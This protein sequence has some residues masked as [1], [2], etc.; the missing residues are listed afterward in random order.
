[1]FE[2]EPN[3]DIVFRN[4]L[5]NLEVLPPADVWDNIPPMPV[6]T[7]RLRIISGIAAGVAALVSLTLLATWYVR[8][9]NTPVLLTEVTTPDDGTRDVLLD[10]MEASPITAPAGA[11]V[12]TM[13]QTTEPA[14]PAL[15]TTVTPAADERA[16]LLAQADIPAIRDQDNAPVEILPDEITI[17]TA[18]R[19]AA[20]EETPMAQLADITP[21]RTGQRFIIGA[22]VSPTM[23]FSPAGDDARLT[24]LINSERSRPTYST[25]VSVGYRI[26]DRLTVHSG[27]GMASMGQT[28]TD[29][30][31]Y[32]GLS[33]YY[34]VKSNYLYS[35]ETASGTILAGNTDL[36]LTDSKDRVA[37]L[38]Q[39]DMAD[40]SKYNLTQVG[41]D[42][43][44]VFRYLELPVMIR[45]RLID[46]K[47]G[48][49]LSGGVAYGLLVGNTAYT[50]QGDDMI[51]VGHTEGVNS[52][53]LSSQVG[54]GM[55]YN[56][57]QKITF[58]LEPVFR[59][60]VTPLSN[61]SGA[62]YKP[63]SLGFYSG[64]YFKF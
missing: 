37:T 42:I 51:T 49:N 58:N 46:R 57:S 28:I 8:N 52:F 41:S 12:I 54:L 45:Y 36:Y 44:Q 30:A 10:I 19:F 35:M 2:R 40:P 29:V 33:D 53:N 14:V 63:Y 1:M 9:S 7:S 64:F 21:A 56:V 31:V 32:A 48:L 62:L 16:P 13:P 22:S 6:R 26:S 15:L 11:K 59:Y 60:Y 61:F 43:H 38:I 5:K 3:I 47:V 39:G 4:G 27:I 24:G 55:E 18:G 34:A 20:A 17:V 50:G 25:G 23:T